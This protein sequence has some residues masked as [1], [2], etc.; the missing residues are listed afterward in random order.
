MTDIQSLLELPY[1]TLA[2]LA[3]GYLAY[4]I[5]YVGKDAAHSPVDVVFLTVVFAFVAKQTT[6]WVDLS[7]WSTHQTPGGFL[8][9]LAGMVSAL[10]AAAVWRR[11][12]QEFVY[13][14]LRR[15]KVS[16]HDGQPNVWRSMMTR[17]LKPPVRLVVVLKSGS[18]LM[19]NQLAVF[20]D[21]P[22]GP[23]LFGQDGSVAMYVTHSHKPAEQDWEEHEA[24]DPARP[25]WGYE[26]SFIPAAEIAR[27]DL[28][29]PA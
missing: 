27:I 26:M 5:A 22:M 16:G 28:T 3:S 11:F 12:L 4:R 21:A 6:V 19:C 13:S 23:C 24:F 18:S 1:E 20:T 2:L 9:S 14:A 10:I 7:V 25:D 29:R 17:T 8:A 15:A